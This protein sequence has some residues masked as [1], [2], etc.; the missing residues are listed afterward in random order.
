[1]MTIKL[2][3]N[4]HS[5]VGEKSLHFL[6]AK[7]KSVRPSTADKY[8][9][10]P[11]G[12]GDKHVNSQS[13]AEHISPIEWKC[14]PWFA[15]RARWVAGE[16]STEKNDEKSRELRELEAFYPSISDIP[17]NPSVS[18]DVKKEN[19]NDSLTPL[20][21]IEEEKSEK[22]V[23]NDIEESHNLQKCVPSISSLLNSQSCEN[24]VHALPYI[25]ADLVAATAIVAAIMKINEQGNMIDSDL[26]LN[27]ANDPIIIEKIIDQYRTA[28]TP[29]SDVCTSTPSK[30]V[31][32]VPKPD[33]SSIPL[34]SLTLEIEA[35]ESESTTTTDSLLTPALH[36]P[37]TTTTPFSSISLFRAQPP[38]KQNEIMPSLNINSPQE[39]QKRET[40][41]ASASTG[42]LN[43]VAETSASSNMHVAAS[44]V[45]S[46]PGA[47]K[48]VKHCKTLVRKRDTDKP[49]E[50]DSGT[51]VCRDSRLPCNNIIK[52]K[53]V[54][55]KDQIRC[56][57]FK[58][59]KGC[60]NGSH[61]PYKHDESVQQEADNTRINAK[62]SK[63]KGE[64]E[65]PLL[66]EGYITGRI[67]A[68]IS[69]STTRLGFSISRSSPTLLP[70][71]TST[72]NMRINI[73]RSSL[74]SR[75]FK[76]VS[77]A[78]GSNLRQVKF[79]SPEDS[80][81]VLGNKLQGKRTL[82][83]GPAAATA[84]DDTPPGFEGKY[85]QNQSP[86]T[87][88]D[89]DDDI[90]PGFEGKHLQNQ[91]K[92]KIPLIPHHIK[93]ECPS[94]IFKK[95]WCVADG[96]ES[97]EKHYQKRREKKLLEAVFPCSSAIPSNPLV[98]SEVEEGS[99]DDS[100]TPEVSLIPIELRQKLE[101][102][103]I[104]ELEYVRPPTADSVTRPT[105]STQQKLK[106]KA[107]ASVPSQQG[108]KKD[109]NY[110]LSLVKDHP[111][112]YRREMQDSSSTSTR[113]DHV[114]DSQRY[115]NNF[116]KSKGGDVCMAEKDNIW[117]F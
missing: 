70:Q 1:M 13:K 27:M 55:T 24:S 116:A 60:R 49:D 22:H 86:S 56:K 5:Q 103:E 113:H 17:P 57:F 59:S 8:D 111:S 77:W 54:K 35:S 18:D 9:D 7:T 102:G 72:G 76:R 107:P 97:M 115:P 32:H 20:I 109:V 74:S 96:M 43:R 25:G 44:S 61:C 104:C 42:K 45:P 90:P 52:S 39:V 114:R 16:E 6:Q 93:W 29:S 37:V 106:R 34:P 98:S 21:P 28:C 89:E 81:S 30:D 71:Q 31:S 68:H 47:E 117:R 69:P 78:S 87:T 4:C 83:T 58:T 108:V 67:S 10:L 36:E 94:L 88:T 11:P 65:F 82:P 84:Y 63:I 62:R 73:K 12:F 2:L 50:K 26:L 48:D 92:A 14:S 46:Q 91:S 15:L 95:E 19:Y 41:L 110:Y 51:R 33:A 85:L 101:D 3:E 66:T 64:V 79:F 23:N 80:P 53:K 100:L 99:Y 38:H 105:S 112:Y 75:K 40:P